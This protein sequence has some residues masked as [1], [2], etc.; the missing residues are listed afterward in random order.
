[1]CWTTKQSLF[2]GALRSQKEVVMHAALSTQHQIVLVMFLGFRKPFKAIQKECATPPHVHP[3][4]RYITACDQF[5]Q[6]FPHIST[7]SDKCWSE[8]AWVRGYLLPPCLFAMLRHVHRSGAGFT[9]IRIY[10]QKG[11]V[12]AASVGFTKVAGIACSHLPYYS[13]IMETERSTKGCC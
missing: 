2:E 11:T 10:A 3:M 7:A 6:A 4:S 8:K 9:R 13:F 1:M 12:S 5:C